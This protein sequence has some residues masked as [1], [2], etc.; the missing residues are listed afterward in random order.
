MQSDL[1]NPNVEVNRQAYFDYSYHEMGIYDLPAVFK[2]VVETTGQRT[3]NYIGHSQGTTQM[4]VGM[5][6]RE[7]FFR[8][9]VDKCVLIAPVMNCHHIDLDVANIMAFN[10]DVYAEFRKSGPEVMP[11]PVGFNPFFRNLFSAGVTDN[12]A[13]VAFL[14]DSE[15]KT[16]SPLAL[17][18]YSGHFPAGTSFKSV[19]HYK[20]NMESMQFRM[21][22]YG[23]EEN[24]KRYGEY[25]PPKYPVE[26]LKDFQIYLVCG[27]TDLLSNPGDYNQL[28]KLL[29]KQSSLAGFNETELGHLGLVNPIETHMEHLSWIIE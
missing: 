18:N 5:M 27:K 10:K 9:H 3:V 16:T 24:L 19:D 23:D 17:T 12:Q 20:Q 22:D 21:Y 13:A 4:L 2:L 6:A 7:A 25:D 8:K 15:G 26:N 28:K 29:E 1:I 14:S 11:S